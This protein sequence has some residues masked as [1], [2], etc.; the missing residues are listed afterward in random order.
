[1]NMTEF[2]YKLVDMAKSDTK[3]VSLGGLSLTEKQLLWL[4]GL[5][6][7]VVL[8]LLLRSSILWIFRPTKASV[9]VAEKKSVESAVTATVS[10]NK[11]ATLIENTEQKPAPLQETP[12]TLLT[13]TSEKKHS[14]QD[15]VTPDS[16]SADVAKKTLTNDYP[17]QTL[18]PDPAKVGQEPIAP[19]E[20]SV[21][22]PQIPRAEQQLAQT[23]ATVVA[24]NTST[25]TA[26]QTAT[27]PEPVVVQPVEHKEQAIAAPFL[28]SE[29]TGKPLENVVVPTPV[30]EQAP[31]ATPAP[32]VTAP[33]PDPL[34]VLIQSTP[35]QKA[36][37]PEIVMPAPIEVPVPAA[38]TPTAVTQNSTILPPLPQKE[39]TSHMVVG[40][41]DETARP[42]KKT[43][44][45]PSDPVLP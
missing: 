20:P 2:W 41:A 6:A 33:K 43:M 3:I 38:A 35:V 4:I 15:Y 25:I 45:N 37:L 10:A 19:T 22:T 9:P 26:P 40:V 7:L 8:V 12:Q 13:D 28:Q 18:K 39:P 30:T 42:I 16:V 27:T 1:M 34:E 31:V 44:F 11:E 5:I 17:Y 14:M 36:E 21:V 24:E 23:V 32:T 29:G